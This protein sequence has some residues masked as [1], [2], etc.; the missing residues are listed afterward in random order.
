MWMDGVVP[1]H[2]MPPI[3]MTWPKNQ[4]QRSKT[5]PTATATGGEGG[6]VRGSSSIRL[7]SKQQNEIRN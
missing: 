7:D 1:R 3:H 5:I 6:V 4:A 2:K